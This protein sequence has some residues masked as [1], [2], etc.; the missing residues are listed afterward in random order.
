MVNSQPREYAVNCADGNGS[1]SN[2]HRSYRSS[3]VRYPTGTSEKDALHRKSSDNRFFEY[4][5]RN[6]MNHRPNNNASHINEKSLQ[7]SKVAI[8]PSFA[9]S[10]VGSATKPD[11]TGELP[12]IRRRETNGKLSDPRLK[13]K[14]KTNGQSLVTIKK[15]S[16]LET[17]DLYGLAVRG[18]GKIDDS[19]EKAAQKV[20]GKQKKVIESGH[21][22]N[23][24]MSKSEDANAKKNI[25]D[26]KKKVDS[27]KMS[28]KINPADEPTNMEESG[29]IVENSVE[30][31]VGTQ[32]LKVIE[33]GDVHSVQGKLTEADSRTQELEKSQNKSKQV[34]VE[35]P[36]VSM[37]VDAPAPVVSKDVEAETPNSLK[38]V[39]TNVSLTKSA[40]V[41]RDCKDETKQKEPP[42]PM[43]VLEKFVNDVKKKE[44]LAQKRIEVV[45]NKPAKKGQDVQISNELEGSAKETTT[46]DIIPP[47]RRS[48]RKAS[49]ISPVRALEN[50]TPKKR[51][52]PNE[53][54]S[55]LGRYMPRRR[56][57]SMTRAESLAA[58]NSP[59]PEKVETPSPKKRMRTRSSEKKF[60]SST[61]NG[62]EFED[63]KK[64]NGNESRMKDVNLV[65]DTTNNSNEKVGPVITRPTVHR[66]LLPSSN[67]TETVQES[68]ADRTIEFSINTKMRE[69]VTTKS[70]ESMPTTE[71]SNSSALNSTSA[72]VS[73][74]SAK[75]P[76]RSGQYD[77][78]VMKLE[79][80]NIASE[81]GKTRENGVGY[82]ARDEKRNLSANGCRRSSRIEQRTI[83]K[84]K[85]VSVR[86]MR[87]ENTAA[88]TSS[89][90]H[91]ALVVPAKKRPRSSIPKATRTEIWMYCD[92]GETNIY[93]RMRQVT[94]SVPVHVKLWLYFAGCKNLDRP[95]P[96]GSCDRLNVFHDW[97]HPSDISAIVSLGMKAALQLESLN[98][99]REQSAG[100]RLNQHAEVDYS[101]ARVVLVTSRTELRQMKG[102]EVV[103]PSDVGEFIVELECAFVQKQSNNTS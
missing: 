67:A 54:K 1:D 28:E 46:S 2:Y 29:E 38:D 101:L 100:S 62:K 35:T 55:P 36:A 43:S 78:A 7:N 44:N 18:S 19:A 15:E 90:R 91:S 21:A 75:A 52:R 70:V 98:E 102:I 50:I 33:H 88:K 77:W 56:T 99:K 42:K 53:P 5:S 20:V 30:K 31:K 41:S 3:S 86:G 34:R 64:E 60:E 92:P 63:T 26:V 13:L 37:D 93:E 40:I 59:S 57:R 45:R 103:H 97:E 65:S 68:G 24:E 85:G 73:A 81:R 17:T 96:I 23:R 84:V 66:F 80:L 76:A 9:L 82:R 95:V 51:T 79:G 61:G 72:K 39:E 83:T 8:R 89:E 4:P 11:L 27:A 58:S 47:P 48:A 12:P 94:S 74:K 16:K 32:K 69:V 6:A 14:N 87:D 22:E 25:G 71:T 10:K 49:S